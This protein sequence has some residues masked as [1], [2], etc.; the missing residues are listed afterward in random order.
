MSEGSHDPDVCSISGRRTARELYVKLFVV[1][2]IVLFAYYRLLSARRESFIPARLAI[3]FLWPTVVVWQVMLPMIAIPTEALLGLGDLRRTK[4]AVAVTLGAL[5]EHETDLSSHSTN[6]DQASK[7]DIQISDIIESLL[8]LTQSS[9]TI[10][11][12]YR[13]QLRNGVIAYD[14]LLLLLSVAAMCIGVLKIAL[15]FNPPTY[16]QNYR[17][18]LT[19]LRRPKKADP[20]IWSHPFWSDLI[21]ASWSSAIFYLF[22]VGP[23][24]LYMAVLELIFVNTPNNKWLWYRRIVWI[25]TPGILFGMCFSLF[26]PTEGTLRAVFWGSL[27]VG[28]IFS[29]TAAL[30]MTAIKLPLTSW[31]INIQ[32]LTD[33][34]PSLAF[35]P[36]APCP[37]AWSDPA[38][39]YVRWLA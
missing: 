36:N 32:Y 13:R 26:R 21:A 39:S 30:T 12:F 38:A 31:L 20:L 3:C 17:G 16:P 37:Q 34:E 14:R 29:M 8:L 24:G 5:P 19:Y 28:L 6:S 15:A 4:R 27:L 2:F 25:R 1:D 18:W 9:F 11:L 35:M 22:G 23:Y 7:N 10:W 33:I